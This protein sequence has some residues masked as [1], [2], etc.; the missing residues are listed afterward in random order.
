MVYV[1]DCGRKSS[2][3]SK[4]YAAYRIS[5]TTCTTNLLHDVFI[6]MNYCSDMF[7]PQLSVIFR[8]LADLSTCAAYVSPCVGEILHFKVQK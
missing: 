5:C 1:K 7:R 2:I 8:K 6:D 4:Y 3:V